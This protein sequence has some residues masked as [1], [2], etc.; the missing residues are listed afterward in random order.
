[1]LN[2]DVFSVE[3]HQVRI[4]SFLNGPFQEIH[5]PN[6]QPI[7]ANI[8]RFDNFKSYD[9]FAMTSFFTMHLFDVTNLS[10]RN[11]LMKEHTQWSMKN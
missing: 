3:L 1:M 2:E 8:G 6:N 9:P 5:S 10:I 4:T 7:R 11:K